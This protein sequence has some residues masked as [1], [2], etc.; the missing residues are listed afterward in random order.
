MLKRMTIL[1]VLAATLCIAG[2]PVLA[3]DV[4]LAKTEA[5]LTDLIQQALDERG[6]PSVSIALVKGDEIVWTAAFGSANVRTKT[7]ATP[8]TIYCTGST[9]KSVTATAIMQLVEQGKCRLT[10][11]VNKH[12]G[13][14]R[15]Q[16]RLQSEQPVNIRHILSHWS[17]LIAGAETKPIWGR[18]LPKTLAAMTA[19]LYSIRAPET[20]WEYNNYA[21]G[22]AGL[23]VEKISGMEYEAYMVEN[24][25]E[26]LGI[27]TPHPVYPSPEM[28]ELMALPYIPGGA[29]GQPKPVAQVHYDVY[30]AGDIY[31]TAEDMARF[32]GAHLNG[33]VWN[34]NRILSEE[35]IEEM[36]TPQF[37]GDYGFG[38]AVKK[39][40]NGHTIIAHG[41][42]IPGQSS[43]MMGDVD[44]RVGVYVMSNSGVPTSIAEAA[45]QLLR[46]EEYVPP[47]ER[48]YIT[49]DQHILDRY[50]GKYDVMGQ[51]VM[52]VVSE[53]GRLFV[54]VPGQP[55]TEL[56]AETE[57]RFRQQGSDWVFT[58]VTDD[59]GEVTHADVESGGMTI[60]A[61]RLKK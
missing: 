46:G 53:G 44:A 58:F 9:F 57:T 28:V 4:D 19:D 23:L 16:D 45:V 21:Y 20:K 49:V 3:A 10:D 14:I 55:K 13:D 30:P 56:L 31:L 11:P 24:V 37:G 61:E 50:A 38:F 47:E 40:D 54:E 15:V 25:L 7:P 35:S 12:L 51:A 8:D 59:A 52:E 17:G 29:D 26:P 48:E 6:V 18:E 2:G 33:G 32:L 42:G 36:H 22:M 60:K 27:R 39:A 1:T 43:Y 34:G 41:G 5:V